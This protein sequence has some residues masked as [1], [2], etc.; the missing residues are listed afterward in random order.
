MKRTMIDAA[1]QVYGCVMVDRKDTMS[2]WWND[3]VKVAGER[4]EFAC[5]AVLRS[6]DDTERKSM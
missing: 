5:K 2:E 6:K 1:R 3:V 4:K